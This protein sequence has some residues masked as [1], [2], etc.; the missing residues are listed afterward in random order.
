MYFNI[1]TFINIFTTKFEFIKFILKVTRLW[2]RELEQY[3]KQIKKYNNKAKIHAAFAYH[4]QEV[5]SRLTIQSKSTKSY[6]GRQKI[7]LLTLK[8]KYS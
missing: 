2:K 4:K 3:H 1:Y 7:A 5:I 8:A 6:I